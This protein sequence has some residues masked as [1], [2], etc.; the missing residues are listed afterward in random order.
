V[1]T[2][3]LPE[4]EKLTGMPAN[5][6]D[7][8]NAA[9]TSLFQASKRLRGVLVKGGHGDN[10]IMTTDH[11]YYYVV[12][13]K[14]ESEALT[15]SFLNTA[16]S[17]GTGCTLASAFTA[18]HALGG[19]YSSSFRQAVFFLQK[20]LRKSAPARVVNNPKGKGGLLHYLG[21]TPYAG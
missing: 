21:C 12:S 7:A 6:Q 3:N 16:N 18:F 11:M 15:H 10:S 4:L 17:H 5:N 8:I 9:G 19:D 14:V 13:G 2:P 20:V 1:L